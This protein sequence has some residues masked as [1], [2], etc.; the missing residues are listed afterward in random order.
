MVDDH[1]L[2]MAKKQNETGCQVALLTVKWP[3]LILFETQ[4]HGDNVLLSC[5]FERKEKQSWENLSQDGV[6]AWHPN[7]F[8]SCNKA[9]KPQAKDLFVQPGGASKVN[10]KKH[11]KWGVCVKRNCSVRDLR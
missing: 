3:E 2:F 9:Y 8:C 6:W 11:M 4:G 10:W 1:N 5:E 7:S